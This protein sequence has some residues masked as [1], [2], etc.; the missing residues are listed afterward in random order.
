MPVTR[1]TPFDELPQLLS[2][3]E[4]LEVVPIGRS[5]LYDLVRSGEVPCA[6][7]GRRVFIPREV[8]RQYLHLNGKSGGEQNDQKR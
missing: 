7:F 3:K 4:F 5:T 2:P 6:R 8:L 1:Q